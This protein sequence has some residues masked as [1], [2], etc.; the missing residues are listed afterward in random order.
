MPKG[1]LVG[2]IGKHGVGKLSIAKYLQDHRGWCMQYNDKYIHQ[3]L[4]RLFMLPENIFLNENTRDT[5][6]PPSNWTPRQ[7]QHRI[8]LMLQKEFKDFD[9]HHIRLAAF[10]DEVVHNL[11]KGINVVIP[12]VYTLHQQDMIV[13]NGGLLVEV[14]EHHTATTYNTPYTNQYYDYVLVRCEMSRDE[15]EVLA[16]TLHDNILLRKHIQHHMPSCVTIAYHT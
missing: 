4:S 1:H 2:L 14:V 9:I 16:S 5:V 12:D 3:A 13:R 7:I 11:Q 6:F 15:I 10:E 8:E